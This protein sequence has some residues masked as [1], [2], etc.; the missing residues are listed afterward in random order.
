MTGPCIYLCDAVTVFNSNQNLSPIQILAETKYSELSRIQT[1]VT[2]V[3][4]FWPVAFVECIG[5]NVTSSI[6]SVCVHEN[7]L[8]MV[9]SFSLNLSQVRI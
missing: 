8:Y 5:Q 1:D 6:K 4:M 2:P 7:S 9:L 3:Q